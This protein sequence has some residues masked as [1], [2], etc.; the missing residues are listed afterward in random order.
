MVVDADP[1]MRSACAEIAASL[2]Y[3]VESTGDMGHARSQLRGRA[4]DILLVNLPAGSNQGL[5]LVSEVKLLYPDTSVI[6]MTASGSVNA[7][8]EAMRCGACDYLTKPFAMDELSTVLDRAA[9]SHLP[10]ARISSTGSMW[11]ICGC[12]RCATAARTYRCWRRTFLTASAA[13]TAS[14]SRSATRRCAP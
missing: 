12:L 4:A 10:S 1:A 8:V 14:S 2:G 13:S 11:S 5:E 9:Q 6:A 7:A 3:A